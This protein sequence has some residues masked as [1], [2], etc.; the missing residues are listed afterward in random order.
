MPRG[1]SGKG[2]NRSGRNGSSG[3][4][5]RRGHGGGQRRHAP[6][7]VG[8]IRLRGQGRGSVDTDFG[9]FELTRGGQREAMNGD[10]VEAAIVSARGRTPRAVVRSVITR[11]HTALLGHMREA[12]PLLEL[13]PLDTRIGQSLYVLPEDPSPSR[14][15]VQPG[16]I[17]AARIV[18]YPTRYSAGVVTLEKVIGQADDLDLA[19]E[20]V[21]ATYGL[22]GDFPDAALEEANAYA[23]AGVAEALA[24]NE[25]RVDLRGLPCVTI[26]PSDARDFDDAVWAAREGAG[27]V[28]TVHIADVSHYVSAGSSLDVEASRRGCSAY[29]VDRVIPML[30]E[31]LCNDLCSLAPGEDRL[32]MTITIHLNAKGEVQRFTC[33]SSAIRSWARLDYDTVDAFLAGALGENNLPV[34]QTSVAAA[35]EMPVAPEVAQQR[36]AE[37][38]HTLDEVRA[39]RE[40]VRHKRG[41]IDFDIAEVRMQL[42]ENGRLVGVRERHRTRATGFVEE[43]M[44]LANECV[45]ER[46][47]KANMPAAYRVHERP[48]PD[49]LRVC[50]APLRELGIVDRPLAAALLCGEA[51]AIQEALRRAESSEGSLL[52][53]TLLLRAQCRAVYSPHNNGHF[54]LGASAYCHF[55]SPIRRYPDVLV[56]RALKA[57]IAGKVD[58]PAMR[59]QA[60][61]L[62]LLCSSCSERERAA[63]AASRDSQRIKM[64]EWMEERIGERFAGTVVGCERFGLFVRLDELGIEGLVPARLLS[65]DRLTYDEARMTLTCDATGQRW[66]LGSHINVVVAGTDIPKGHVDLAPCEDSRVASRR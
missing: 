1:S 66:V 14:L 49:D 32:A 51:P 40:A 20:S 15:Q 31:R 47:S 29:L 44:L 6:T 48:L 39:L 4:V 61:Q 24:S 21:V 64:A 2:R 8:T 5:A 11:A 12:G 52:A 23:G 43:A 22:A 27:Y 10:T 7:V 62:P 60:E 41:A 19:L 42:D 30:P 57:L 37:A 46:V 36:I 13:I 25:R 58:S 18:E 65:H 63:D 34:A 28:L 45:A 54:A 16:D 59:H 53:S 33:A 17:V 26:D 38:L 55:T 3:R 9:S 56:H 50:I 35:S